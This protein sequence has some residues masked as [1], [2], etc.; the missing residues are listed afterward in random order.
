[1]VDFGDMI[2]TSSFRCLGKQLGNFSEKKKKKKQK[3]SL[4]TFC[5][6]VRSESGRIL[7]VGV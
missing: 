5:L 6:D 2:F 7:G 4:I 3:T 1:M